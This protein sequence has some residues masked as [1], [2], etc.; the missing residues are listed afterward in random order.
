MANIWERFMIATK[1]F[2]DAFMAAN[3]QQP[4][5][6]ND[7]SAR[8]LRYEIYWA[9]YE[10]S[11]YRKV[12]GW[13]EA[14]KAEYGLYKYIRNIYNPTF[15]LGEFWKSHLMG[16]DL[17]PLAGD[18]KQ[19]PSALPI[20][21][22]NEA[23]RPAL[24]NIWRWSN[25]KVRKDT[26]GLWGTIM[27][28]VVLR[29]VDD[30]DRGK[31]YLDIV[32][33]GTI[34]DLTRDPFGNVKGYVITEK[35]MDPDQP[36]R[37]VTYKE[38]ATRDGQSVR[39][40][41]FKNDAPYAWE[42]QAPEWTESYG[43]I[44]MVLVKNN[45]VGMDWGWSELHADQAKFREADDLA[46]KLSDQIRKLVDSPWLFSGV[47][48]PATKNKTM[49]TTT[50]GEPT[51]ARKMPGREEIPA[52]Y[53]PVG[54]AATPLVAPIDIAGTTAY[55]QSI[56][57]DIERDYP[58]LSDTLNNV[59][60]DVSGRAL[61]INRQPSEGKV[62]QRRVNYDDGLVRAQQMAMT[63]GGIRGYEGFKGFNIGSYDAGDLEHSIGPRPVFD[64]DAADDLEIENQ[65]WTVAGL[66]KTAGYSLDLFLERQGWPEEAIN[67]LKENPE[68]KARIA[69][70][71][72]IQ[73]IPSK[74][75]PMN[76]GMGGR[77][78]GN[79]DTK[80]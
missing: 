4:D 27:G 13:A 56:L 54:A 41:L 55:I 49:P 20:I 47:D 79:D 67:K 39:Y 34:S 18:G 9:Y 23:I 29:V 2:R 14:Y 36:N 65:L 61:R 12:H 50:G 11:V 71:E 64:K 68:F 76:R 60:G 70:L 37:T 73:S 5:D 30:V 66:A 77:Q 38:V 53:G 43:F 52:L 3:V 21:T 17:D 72:N 59:Q 32:H 16:G 26:Y 78:G 44:P 7:W 24:A 22:K 58:E 75:D 25:W 63:I 46:S 42:M 62:K 48:N 31:V 74:T 45:D 19:V 33:P 69:A 8:Q 15:R 1:A 10:N 80:A 51:A 40:Q 6:F 28:D 57:K 35:R